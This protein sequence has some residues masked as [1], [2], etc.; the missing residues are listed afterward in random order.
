M[1]VGERSSEEGGGDAD[2][3]SLC[4]LEKTWDGFTSNV[5]GNKNARKPEALIS[6]SLKVWCRY[7]CSNYLANSPGV[8]SF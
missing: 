2:Q 4:F 1:Q 5:L 8:T 7:E 3:T 6:P